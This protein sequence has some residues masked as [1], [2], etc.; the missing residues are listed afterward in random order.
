MRSAAILVLATT[1]TVFL[2]GCTSGG[3]GQ[4]GPQCQTQPGEWVPAQGECPGSDAE[5]QQKCNAFCDSHPDCCGERSAYGGRTVLPLPSDAEV[6]ELARSYPTTIKAIDEGPMIYSQGGP[7]SVLNDSTLARM[8]DTGFNTVQIMLIGKKAANGTIVFNEE[9][10]AV[11]LNDIVAIKKAGMAVWVVLDM[12]G[13][14]NASS[15]P[16]ASYTEFK[17]GFLNLVSLSAP[18]MEEYK[19]EYFTPCNE[20]DKY[21]KEQTQ[22]GTSGQINSYLEEF[23]MVMN[24]EARQGFSGKLISKITQISK[25]DSKVV[26]ASLVG[27]DIGGVDVGPNLEGALPVDRYEQEFGDYQLYA[28]AAAANGVPWMN[29]EYWQGDFFTD[30]PSHVRDNQL[31]YANVSFNAYLAVEPAGVGYTWNDFSTFS[32]QPKGEATR[33]AIK[34][35]FE[36]I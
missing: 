28:T 19:V 22:W 24:A 29:A 31:A 21:F 30:Y 5:T 3:P 10:N 20:P 7:A 34:T 8:K 9:N 36:K 18:L 32:L 6:A 33:L 25:H 13:Y 17:P 16:Y 23:F 11:L 14:A 15:N 35:F 1:L 26:N 27:V 12:A 4:G 2:S